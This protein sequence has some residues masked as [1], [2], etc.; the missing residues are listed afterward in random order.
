M[1]EYGELMERYWQGT[2]KVLTKTFPG[3]VDLLEEILGF[4]F[5][6]QEVQEE[7]AVQKKLVPKQ[8]K[9]GVV[10]QWDSSTLQW[11]GPQVVHRRKLH[12][13]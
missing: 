2:A 7:W 6:V 13:W 5:R 3:W 9:A 11:V 8:G 10:N 4:I 12:V 1:N